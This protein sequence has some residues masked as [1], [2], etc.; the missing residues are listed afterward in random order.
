MTQVI[1]ES[2]IINSAD[3]FDRIERMKNRLLLTRPE[4]DLENARIL[5]ESFMETEGE[6][7]VLRK[8]KAFRKQ[9]AEKTVKIWDDELIVG[10]PGSKIRGGILNAD[11]CWS[12]LD[13]E[14]ETINS[15]EHDP[16]HLTDEDRETFNN[17]IKPFWK[18]RSNYEEWLAQ[19]PDSTKKLKEHGALFIDRKAVRGF[20]EVTAGYEW[21]INEGIERIEETIK[22]R[23]EELDITKP[24]DYEKKFY[25][26]SLL[27]VAEGMKILGN[28]YEMEAERQ[29]ATEKDKERKNEL[30]VIAETCKQVPMKPAR[31]FREAIQSVYFYQTFIF[32]EQ[33]AAS[34]NPGRMDQY[35]LPF[36]SKD[37]EDGTLTKEEAQEILNC[38]WI[39]FSEPCLFQ[40]KISAQFSAGY[41]M[42]QNVCVGGVD[43][44]GKDAVNDL[45]YLIL[46][47]TMDVQLY[48]PSL[49]VK[50][51]MAKNPNS[52]LKK[53]VEL[54]SLGTGF[55]AFHNDEVGIKM[56][57]NKGIPLKE[58]YDWNPCGCVET[59]L[60]GRIKHYTALADV[61]LGSI[62]EY[63]LLNGVS[64]KYSEEVSLKTGDPVEF[65][66]FGEFL[67][68]VKNQISYVIRGVVEGS[69]V[70][71]EICMNRP[72]PALSL[73]F[74]DCI[75]NAKD[76]AWGGAKYNT[77]NGIIVIGVAD[78]I[79][80]L[81]AVRHLVYDTKQ[82]SMEKLLDALNSNFRDFDSIFRMCKEA[83][84][85]GNDDSMVD[86]ITSDIMTYIADEIESYNS[87]FGKMT[88]GI[89]PVSGN[90]PLGMEVG[91]LPS[92]RK[93]WKPLADGISPNAGTDF[94][95][96]GAILKSA[97]DIPHDR[98]VQGTLL[99]M[100][101][102]P[103]MLTEENG[104]MQMM[105]LLKSLCSLG[106]FHVQFNVI[107]KEKLLDAQKHPDKY[108][109]LLVR[110]AGYTAYFTELGVDVQNDIISRTV[111]HGISVG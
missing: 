28:R 51:N 59:N 52:F 95:G 87:K 69:H 65:K 10:S 8:A 81:A 39:K 35:L 50:Y 36:Y 57:M 15:R 100:M 70:I 54:I 11:V 90:T 98:F 64:R 103:A 101:V 24:G 61:N 44:T 62:I 96:P 25:L 93:A 33:N 14:L 3:R 97:A 20:G 46:Q 58:A 63:T 30:L 77:G 99:N 37:I 21:L 84:K 5:T 18:G 60:E 22:A 102:E 16:F 26:E 94:N 78:L 49:S 83:P 104:K 47:A 42:F 109:G 79:N 73:T 88:P 68:A 41:P 19:I 34:Y 38:L 110:V 43:K 89:L 1:E 86:D 17:V 106:I 74:K 105:A 23:S 7:M 45:S 92:G 82:V 9:C 6:P 29:A 27:I 2:K 107:D 76:Y 32:M 56:V 85:Y 40:D 91:A 75:G 4:I 55:P 48:Q 71:D 67:Q 31:N 53:I 80:S 111:Q 72:C 66:E 12:V 13:D 108:K